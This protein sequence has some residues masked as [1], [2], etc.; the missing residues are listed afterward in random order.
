MAEQVPGWLNTFIGPES[1][2]KRPPIPAVEAKRANAIEQPESSVDVSLFEHSSNDPMIM[3]VQNLDALVS[4]AES[5]LHRVPLKTLESTA[6]SCHSLAS[7]FVK[8]VPVSKDWCSSFTIICQKTYSGQRFHLSFQKQLILQGI[9]IARMLQCIGLRLERV[10]DGVQCLMNQEVDKIKE[11]LAPLLQNEDR[12]PA[13]LL[14]CLKQLGVRV[15]DAIGA[16]SPLAIALS[17]NSGSLSS[18]IRHVA[19][20]S[21]PHDGRI[22]ESF[23]QQEQADMK[24]DIDLGS[25]HHSVGLLETNF[26][27]EEELVSFGSIQVN[28]DDIQP[29]QPEAHHEAKQI[30]SA[31]FKQQNQQEAKHALNVAPQSRRVAPV[32]NAFSSKDM[33]GPL[34]LTDFIGEDEEAKSMLANMKLPTNIKIRPKDVDYNQFYSQKISRAQ[35]VR[36]YISDALVV[37]PPIANGKWT[38]QRLAE[39]KPMMQMIQKILHDFRSWF[40]KLHQASDVHHRF[41]FLLMVDNSGS[42]AV[43]TNQLFETL[44]LLIE[45]LRRLE[46][47]FAIAR[48]GGRTQQLLLKGLYQ[49]FDSALGEQILESFSFDEGT[50]PATAFRRLADKVWPDALSDSPGYVTHRVAILVTDGLT[51]ESHQDD[52]KSVMSN[53]SI[54]FSILNIND[55]KIRRLNKEALQMVNRLRLVINV[56]DVANPEDLPW[57]LV[58]LLMSEFEKSFQSKNKASAHP[59]KS[60]ACSVDVPSRKIPELPLVDKFVG[61]LDVATARKTGTGS[62]KR[63]FQTSSQHAEIPLVEDLKEQGDEKV[64][65]NKGLLEAQ[66]NLSSLY[67][68]LSQEPKIKE[69]DALWSGFEIQMKPL[70]NEMTQV[71]EDHVFPNNK[72]T[73]RKADVRG[74]CIYLPGLLKA[75]TTEWS[76]KKWLSTQTAG[77]KR[78]Y[79]VVI[80]IDLSLS[81]KGHLGECLIE[82]VMTLV[83]A[84]SSAG[85][86]N[87]SVITFG[88]KVSLIKRESDE[89]SSATKMLLLSQ[90]RFEH[91]ATIDA[92]AIYC[93]LD[94]LQH[95]SARG[96]KKL[97]VFSDGFGA[98]G[99]KL[100]RALRRAEHDNVE[101]VAI[102][103]GFD[104]F[105]VGASYRTWV[106]ASLPSSLPEA[107]RALYQG[108]EDDSQGRAADTHNEL[109]L[110]PDSAQSLEEVHRQH[111]AVFRGLQEQLAANR[112]QELKVVE[113]N[114][115][116]AVTVDLVFVLD[117]SG[118]MTGFLSAV[119]NHISAI[120]HG[121]VPKIKEKYDWVDMKINFGLVAFKDL[122]DVPRF[123]VAPLTSDAKSFVGTIQSLQAQ[124]GGDIPEDV[125]GALQ[126]AAKL[127]W[128]SKAKFM[129]LITDA[130]AHGPE[131]HDLP[132]TADSYYSLPSAAP[133]LFQDLASKN[134]DLM[135]GRVQP[136]ATAKMEARMRELYDNKESDRVFKAVDL[137]D[138]KEAPKV[139]H[140]VFCLDESGSMANDPWRSLMA[141]L[142]GFIRQRRND[143]ATEDIVSVVQFDHQ[144][145]CTVDQ[146]SLSDFP[147]H[148]SFNGGGTSFCPAL[149]AAESLIRRTP[150]RYVPIMIFMTDGCTQDGEE[151]S[152][153]LCSTLHANYSRRGF[154]CHTVGFGD[155]IAT[156]LLQSMARNGGGRYHAA[157]SGNDLAQVFIQI[158]RG[159]QTTDG[160]YQAIGDKISDLVANKVMLDYL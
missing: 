32:G 65:V 69:S 40:T 47:P 57:H 9:Y 153:S 139:H 98:S 148:L 157:P 87:F 64:D 134:I 158:A 113:G 53:K 12:L 31:S 60:R 112:E 38:Y 82:G 126:E 97:F 156:S 93:G 95:S 74:S 59:S 71:L 123:T 144:A 129:F 3:Q 128:S 37:A 108:E 7:G 29:V 43:L 46:C 68:D 13:N 130:P 147:S 143:Q 142:Q 22:I 10:K 61:K 50:Y 41:E 80:A 39:A 81:M 67:A 133:A 76:Y 18:Q 28:L 36:G 45:V 6:E 19:D 146:A 114:S 70:I 63:F 54:Q 137:T 21:S 48:F 111:S 52:Y 124:G 122:S 51:H 35:Q 152:Q 2:A 103:I 150:A 91:G 55:S 23:E 116:G 102:A 120:V 72:F 25:F 49:A 79:G 88:E 86:E 73:R 117:I 141:A 15:D 99:V 159:F 62:A 24:Q 149:S 104:N 154:Q 119:K 8:L 96:P 138:S 101:V 109:I 84:L 33:A 1:E 77:G 136:S 115:P 100:S 20:F 17:S 105:N 92:D 107:L 27:V 151:Q 89:W 83:S 26:S 78:S 127:K 121:I 135:F 85:I 132:Q 106:T 131:F 155:Y 90:L 34:Q 58:K 5:L 44:V 94:L 140:W 42:M 66:Q 110:A 30:S 11:H 118:S 4:E 16:P 125:I 145:R 160:L 75:I 56:A 14:Q